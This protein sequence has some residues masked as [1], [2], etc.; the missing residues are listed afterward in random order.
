M[1]LILTHFEV[2]AKIYSFENGVI[3]TEFRVKTGQ[4]SIEMQRAKL[5]TKSLKWEW[6]A[7]DT[8][9]ATPQ[10]IRESSIESK[11]GINV[12]I[13]NEKPV[14]DELEM[15]FHKFENNRIDKSVLHI[16]L[17]F[18]GWRCVWVRF[19]QD[20]K[21]PGYT[22]RCM[23]WVPPKSN[24]GTLLIDF[25]EFTP[26]VSWE[27]ISDY[28]YRVNNPAELDDFLYTSTIKPSNLPINV[29]IK[30]KEA[31]QIIA[32][33]IDNW[34]LGQINNPQ[35]ELIAKRKN[36]FDKYVEKATRSV[37]KLNLTTLQDGTVAGPGLFPID[38]YNKIYDGVKTLTFREI[39]N[40]YLFQLAYD[41]VKNNNNASKNKFINILNWY[42]NQGWAEGSG[43]GKLR[44]EM[45]RSGGFYTASYL[46]RN[47]IG[48]E[49]H[50]TLLETQ[51]WYNLLGEI[52][53]VND[54]AGENTD[55]IRA[56][57]LPKLYSVLMMKDEKEQ[58][59]ALKKFMV[60]AENAI[61]PA[62]GYLDMIKP[63][64]SGYHHRGA[65]F[66][67]YYPDA[68]YVVSLIYYFLHNTPFELSDNAFNTIKKSLLT[69]R[70]TCANYSVPAATTGRFPYNREV[71]SQILPA[72]AYLNATKEFADTELN[73]NFIELWQPNSEPLKSLI[74]NV[75]SEITF[76]NTIGEVEIMVEMSK[77]L[78]NNKG[79]KLEG[80]LFL[81]YAGLM[82]IRQNDWVV[83]IK[84]F[85]K[86]IWDFEASKSEN[87]YGR[88]L[89]YGSIEYTNLV[90]YNNNFNLS[91]GEWNWSHISGT[92]AKYLPASKLNFNVNSK[93]RNFSDSPFL[94]ATILDSKNSVFSVALHD[95]TFDKSFFAN[96]TVFQFDS[97][98]YCVG[99]GIN[100]SDD[101]NEVHTTLFQNN[102]QKLN[103]LIEIDNKLINS[104]LYNISPRYIK[105]NYG[106]AY[107][108]DDE[109]DDVNISF[110]NEII[111]G[112]INHGKEPK[113]KK[114]SYL[115]IPNAS[116]EVISEMVN[117]RD[118]Y[119]NMIQND[120][121]AHIVEYKKRNII[122]A[123]IFNP[124]EKLNSTLI[125]S[126]NTPSVFVFQ[127]LEGTLNLAFSIPD[128]KRASASNSDM[129]ITSDIIDKGTETH[130]KVQLNGIFDVVDSDMEIDVKYEDRTTHLEYK[131]AKN[132]ETYHLKLNKIKNS[133]DSIIGN[134]F[135]IERLS[136]EGNY[137]IA[138]KN[139]LPFEYC[140]YDATGKLVL[141]SS[142]Q[143][144][145]DTFSLETYP[146]GV[147]LLS[148]LSKINFQRKLIK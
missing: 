62:N 131:K 38:Y 19:R 104:N 80:T 59:Q 7:S 94:G 139:S 3:P 99:S 119:F 70:F 22:I 37:S 27:R 16:N 145:S 24:S 100:C 35:D 34:L 117:Y 92:T 124:F 2:E 93:H 74:E 83:N 122:S 50:N 31:I 134:Y 136:S 53:Q 101:S 130:L 15:W 14:D 109:N 110:R 127:E 85:S 12:W 49:Q 63:D 86:Y 107:V 84:G 114:Y 56:L 48:A 133:T 47:L 36:A 1:F 120:N 138:S 4:L 82:T 46:M 81:P 6:G 89:S 116:D 129:L 54:Y 41:A 21:H 77:M 72:F 68:L 143:L 42:N 33:R 60:Y 29:S 25:L 106:I 147:Y 13:Y 142:K 40:A 17:N 108:F 105:D 18:K 65:Y 91:L 64:F 115:M 8:L 73:S 55:K 66:N 10:G 98:L 67:A 51:K 112:F 123:V 30:E 69:F 144:L 141:K 39:N 111:T 121:I 125:C 103:G 90:N 132:G 57:M 76:K 5:G 43:L 140:I 126:V 148:I 75:K 61:S 26:N 11:G 20:M 45:L 78:N 23:K 128:M 9:I 52:Y 102:K 28:Q 32:D 58:V 79:N 96:K 95:N 44:F 146:D 113:Q 118:N 87:I 88:Y 137:L 135:T 71:L 97:I